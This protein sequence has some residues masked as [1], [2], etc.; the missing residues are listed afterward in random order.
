MTDR[1][2]DVVRGVI[3]DMVRRINPDIKW[4]TVHIDDA[5]GD[6]LEVGGDPLGQQG[7]LLLLKQEIEQGFE[8]TFKHHELTGS[9]ELRQL[10]VGQL[11]QA[12]EHKLDGY[13]LS[14]VT[15]L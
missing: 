9:H 1:R 3:V 6:L 12:V 15:V 13:D 8:F 5:L 14:E 10:T 2:T 7:D 11:A 4:G